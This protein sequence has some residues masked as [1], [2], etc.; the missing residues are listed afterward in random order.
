MSL[1]S[2]ENPL[3]RLKTLPTGMNWRGGWDTTEQ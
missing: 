2:L 3:E 1:T